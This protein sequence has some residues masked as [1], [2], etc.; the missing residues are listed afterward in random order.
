MQAHVCKVVHRYCLHGPGF[1]IVNERTI[2]TIDRRWSIL[3]LGWQINIET[4]KHDPN[5][6]H[7]RRIINMHLR[8]SLRRP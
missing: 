8:S 2:T 5:V 6:A 4:C 3:E 7:W 1:H